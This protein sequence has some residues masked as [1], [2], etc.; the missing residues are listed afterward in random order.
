MVLGSLFPFQGAKVLKKNEKT[1]FYLHIQKK[2]SIFAR[3]FG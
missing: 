3:F 1:K 2:S